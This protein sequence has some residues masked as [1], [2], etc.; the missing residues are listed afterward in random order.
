MTIYL[1]L[2]GKWL[3]ILSRV[4]GLI[5]LGQERVIDDSATVE[6]V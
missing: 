6:I 2:Q 1:S 3:F 5:N 4:T